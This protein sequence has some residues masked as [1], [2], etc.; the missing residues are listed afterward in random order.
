MSVG[1]FALLLRY[2]ICCCDILLNKYSHCLQVPRKKGREADTP[3]TPQGELM[4]MASADGW[5]ALTSEDNELQFEH[6][7]TTGVFDHMM[8]GVF[9]FLSEHTGCTLTF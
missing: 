2:P 9:A 1:S 3:P 4:A 7:E 8:E 5:Q 6:S